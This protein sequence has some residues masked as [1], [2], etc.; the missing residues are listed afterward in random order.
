MV[1][2]FG[3]LFELCLKICNMSPIS[4]KLQASWDEVKERMKENDIRLTDA[5][6]VYD[7]G[8]EEELLLRLEKIMNKTR[9][10]IIAYI[11]SISANTGLSG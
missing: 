2:C 11:E 1:Y 6:L 9:P 4:L 7:P 3:I 5:D 10:E 8:H